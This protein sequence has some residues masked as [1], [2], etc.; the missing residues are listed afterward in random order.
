MRRIARVDLNQE[1]IVTA[2]RAAGCSVQVLS[3]IGAGCPDLLCGHAGVNYLL[4][5]KASTGKL[6]PDQFNWV[7][8]WRGSVRVVRSP[9]EALAAVGVE[10][11]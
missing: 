5:V 2:L 10:Q 4:E 6:T 7:L 9:E 1:L 11:C 8:L 3:T